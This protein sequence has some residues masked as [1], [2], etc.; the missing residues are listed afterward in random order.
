[1]TTHEDPIEPWK[2]AIGAIILIVFIASM[3][4]VGKAIR[5]NQK[6]NQIEQR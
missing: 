3:Y 1:M 6:V 5:E 2:I 4:F